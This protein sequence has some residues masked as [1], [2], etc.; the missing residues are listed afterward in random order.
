MKKTKISFYFLFIAFFTFITI[1]IV[2]VQKSYNNLMGPIKEV[3]KS[4]LLNPINPNLDTSIIQQV[5]SRP[6][7]SNQ[8]P[9]PVNSSSS[10]QP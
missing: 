8:L 1:F 6:E 9:L 2:I 7:Y 10:A 5:E 4:N 3:Q